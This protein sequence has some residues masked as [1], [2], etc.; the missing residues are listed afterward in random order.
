MPRDIY[1]ILVKFLWKKASK[2][3]AAEGVV[4]SETFDDKFVF[5]G[6]DLPA[7]PELPSRFYPDLIFEFEMGGSIVVKPEDYLFLS[8]QM[9]IVVGDRWS[10]SARSLRRSRLILDT[11]YNT[12]HVCEAPFMD[13]LLNE[14]GI[15]EL[16]VFRKNPDVESIPTCPADARGAFLTSTKF[17]VDSVSPIREYIS[18]SIGSGKS[19]ALNKPIFDA[20]HQ[21]V[22]SKSLD[23]SIKIPLPQ[24]A[25]A[26]ADRSIGVPKA[27]MTRYE[28]RVSLGSLS[29]NFDLSFRPNFENSQLDFGADPSSMGYVLK[30]AGKI[31]ANTLTIKPSSG[32]AF[33]GW[34]GDTSSP[35]LNEVLG[36]SGEL[37]EVEMLFDEQLDKWYILSRAKMLDDSWKSMKTVFDLQSK[38]KVTPMFLWQ[39]NKNHLQLGDSRIDFMVNF[40]VEGEMCTVN[41]SEASYVTLGYNSFDGKVVSWDFE[42]N[43]FRFCEAL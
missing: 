26:S 2:N 16:A 37:N 11:V 39:Q 14:H 8:G 22:I 31:A 10:F 12:I 24:A 3:G 18:L 23:T 21:D 30:M 1:E 28:M 9:A 35:H 25:D 6:N 32:Q 41:W 5:K 17:G 43:I 19:S 13:M 33:L 29:T 38:Y 34:K 15:L 36:C 4:A 27:F 40:V 20:V 7:I 42:Q